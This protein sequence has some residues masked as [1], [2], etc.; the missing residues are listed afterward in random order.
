[1]HTATP[2]AQTVDVKCHKNAQKTSLARILTTR[3]ATMQQG[4]SE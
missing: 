3:E 2:L 1:M 4:S